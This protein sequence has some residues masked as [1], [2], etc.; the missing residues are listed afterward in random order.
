[1]SANIDTVAR[2]V[3]QLFTVVVSEERL[4]PSRFEDDKPWCKQDKRLFAHNENKHIT[5]NKTLIKTH[6]L[7]PQNYK[8]QNAR[9]FVIYEIVSQS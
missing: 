3:R 2:L 9:D 5:I 4:A 7:P 8:E 6:I 1:M